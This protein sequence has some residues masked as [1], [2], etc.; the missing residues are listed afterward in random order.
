MFKKGQLRLRLIFSV[1][2]MIKIK[3]KIKIRFW[4]KIDYKRSFRDRFSEHI[5][6]ICKYDVYSTSSEVSIHFVSI[7][8]NL[9]H[10][11]LNLNFKLLN[12][13]IA[14]F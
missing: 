8:F 11:F 14:K 9:I 10:L 1:F 5:D 13:K 4:L 12:E 7:E 3:L 6:K 2:N